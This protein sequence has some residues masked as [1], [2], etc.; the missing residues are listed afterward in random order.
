VGLSTD[1]G[2]TARTSEWQPTSIRD[3]SGLLFFGSCAA[4]VVV[5]ARSGRRVPWPTLAWLGVFAALGTYAERGVA[6]WPFAAVAAV[7]GTI[8]LPRTAGAVAEG[9]RRINSALAVGIALV[10]I[11]LLP[12]WR[13]VDPKTS[14]PIAVITDAPPGITD[15][16]RALVR[17]GDRV[18]NAQR[19]GSWFEF[20]MP[21]ALYAVDSRIEFIPADVWS[22]YEGIIAGVDGWT[23][24]LT[25]WGVS[26]AVLEQDDEA[27]IARFEDAGWRTVHADEDG[28]VLVGP[29]RSTG[30]A[31]R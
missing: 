3:I 9:S 26:I 21:T 6:W 16:L 19:W 11:A 15:A 18:F 17:P 29:D 28:S 13:P 2:V 30:D 25:E 22:A 5:I 4:L 20:A 14:V 8:I 31:G 1:A 10:A 24:Q 27:T 7:A 23:D 12:A